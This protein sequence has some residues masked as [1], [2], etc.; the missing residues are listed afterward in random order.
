MKMAE[1]MLLRLSCRGGRPTGRRRVSTAS[2]LLKTILCNSIN[3]PKLIIPAVFFQK[4]ESPR[5]FARLE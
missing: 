1:E 5:T 3:L 2:D 4:N